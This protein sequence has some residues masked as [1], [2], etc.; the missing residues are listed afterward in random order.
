[1]KWYNS[2]GSQL[3]VLRGMDLPLP[4]L[5]PHNT[6]KK[7]S[8]GEEITENHWI[9]L[10]RMVPYAGVPTDM[11]TAPSAVPYTPAAT[12][13]ADTHR[14]Q[15]YCLGHAGSGRSGSDSK[16][17]HGNLV[18]GM[19]YLPLRQRVLSQSLLGTPRLFLLGMPFEASFAPKC[20][21]PS[22]RFLT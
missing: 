19:R 22:A 3:S 15:R 13:Y 10:C 20:W 11:A 16:M 12:D 21:G 5:G 1:M 18:L 17:L 6:F 9:S 4:H 7:K 2:M 8:E 14:A